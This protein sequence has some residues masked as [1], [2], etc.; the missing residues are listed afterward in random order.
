MKRNRLLTALLIMLL[1]LALAPAILADDH[2]P[3]QASTPPT[4]LTS[5]P[6]QT[7][8]VSPWNQQDW[9]TAPEN[10]QS[11]TLQTVEQGRWTLEQKKDGDVASLS[12]DGATCYRIR[13]YIFRRNDG[14]AP[15]M[16]GSTT[17]GPSQAQA[18]DI[19]AP[20]PRLVPA[21]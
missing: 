6:S 15:K 16:V 18:K 13:A 9:T 10:Q 1:A 3:A 12:H 20:K 11:W 8:M 17:C 5:P 19:R 14:H 21:D 7:W 4:Q 2:P